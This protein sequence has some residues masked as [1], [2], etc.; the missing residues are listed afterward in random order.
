[1]KVYL[2]I[3]S[4]VLLLFSCQEE[5]EEVLSMDDILPQSERYNGMQTDSIEENSEA[6]KI[7]F[8]PFKYDSLIEIDDRVFPERFGPD[9][10]R[11]YRFFHDEFKTDY[12]ELI[13]EDSLKTMNAFFN[14]LDCFGDD[15]DP[16]SVGEKRN[17]Q[18]ESMQLWVNDTAL[19]YVSSAQKGISPEWK[20]YLKLRGY[21]DDWNYYIVQF[22]RASANWYTF[23]DGRQT[24]LN[25]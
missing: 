16:H 5:S 11:K 4:A 10:V 18:K 23:E 14:W 1:M 19:I 24:K 20:E 13:F 15:C 25:Q 6:L 12:Y 9:S 7:N 21:E 17:F 8:N 2:F 22:Y 3:L